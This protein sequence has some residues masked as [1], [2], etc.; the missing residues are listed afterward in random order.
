MTI[1]LRPITP[2]FIGSGEEYYPQDFYIDEEDN[3]YFIDR[4]KFSRYVQERGLFDKFIEVSGSQN[5]DD[6]L[7][8]IS[9]HFDPS[10]AKSKI[11]IESD[12]AQILNETYSR[13][14]EAF[15]KD[16]FGFYPIVPGSTL[17]GLIRTALLDYKVH[18]FQDRIEQVARK[19]L[20]D[21]KF[22][23][24]ETIVFCNEH[25]NRQ[26]RLQFDPKLDILKALFIS[27]L[28]PKEYRLKIIQPLNRPFNKDRDNK[29]P[30][31][32]EAL[33]NG[34]F[35][36]EIRIEEHLLRYDHNL[37]KNR[38]FQGDEALS[39]DLI[40]KALKEF[41]SKILSIEN[42][43]FRVNTIEYEPYMIKLGKHAGAGSKSLNDIREIW[44]KQIRKP[45]HY[46]FS[47]WIYKNEKPLGWAKLQFG[48]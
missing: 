31:A 36:G 40:K 25:R 12:L 3:F 18:R 8:F 42:N 38:Y 44:I 43:R 10:C 15:I 4:A 35:V 32:L 9:K 22:K 24:L 14:V 45:S 29:I 19:K 21:I 26:E 20:E 47:I 46:Q 33:V 34:E 17:K 28:T 13:P 6:L 41:F 2:I 23:E 16:R 39:I 27:D 48:G 30:I 37:Q 1:L 7:G 5:I 11:E